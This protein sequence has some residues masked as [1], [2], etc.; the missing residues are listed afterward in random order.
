MAA[1][2]FSFVKCPNQL[3]R[4]CGSRASVKKSRLGSMT[5]RKPLRVQSIFGGNKDGAPEGGGSEV[6]KNPFSN[7]SEL[8]KTAKEAQARAGEEAA[9][10]Q[11]ELSGTLYEGYDVDETVKVVISGN[12]EPR[13]VEITEDAMNNGPEELS[14]RMVDAMKDAH[15]KSVFGMKDRMKRLY[16]DLGFPMPPQM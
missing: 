13:E 7:F 3:Y 2:T 5:A 8:L 10:A 6:D 12:Q 16:E 9:K 1:N 15:Q 14:S 11:E 4:M